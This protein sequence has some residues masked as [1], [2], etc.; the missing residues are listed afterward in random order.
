MQ[1]E[2]KIYA[3]VLVTAFSIVKAFLVTHP[4]VSRNR[5]LNTQPEQV[6][7]ISC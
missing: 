5:N 1:M 3:N 4:N 6:C 7:V 2:L